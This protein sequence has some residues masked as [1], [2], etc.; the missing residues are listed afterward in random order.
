MNEAHYL[1]HVAHYLTHGAHYLTYVAHY[2]TLAAH[3]PTCSTIDKKR[4]RFYRV[5]LAEGPCYHLS[6]GLTSE[7][8]SAVQL[9]KRA[10]T[11]YNRILTTNIFLS[12]G[13]CDRTGNGGL[14]GSLQ[15][16][17]SH[18]WQRLAYNV[19]VVLVQLGVGP[20]VKV[21]PWRWCCGAAR[22]C[23]LLNSNIYGITHS[24]STF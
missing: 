20:D 2:L 18:S 15:Q 1:K 14:A 11:E 10:S 12:T 4:I 5:R 8:D 19:V 22:S 3:Y 6:R 23:G 16:E 9:E 24:A 13:Q 17:Y 21:T 7:C